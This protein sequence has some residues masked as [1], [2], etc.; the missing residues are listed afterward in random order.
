MKRTITAFVLVAFYCSIVSCGKTQCLTPAIYEVVFNS[1]DS[2]PD[3][4]ANVVQYQKGSGFSN[5]L[6]SYNGSVLG[7][8]YDADH[9]ELMLGYSTSELTSAYGYDWMIT[10]LPS[11]KVYKLTN[12]SHSNGTQSSG[13]I[14]E[15][16]DRCVNTV[17]YSVN[18]T[19]NSAGSPT[20]TSSSAD[21]ILNINY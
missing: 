18:G 5:I 6:N 17:S 11:G 7:R 9:K 3:T 12:V 2:I 15:I 4:S 20:T 13:G 19:I 14:G 21:A 8:T 16:R 1:T 10:L